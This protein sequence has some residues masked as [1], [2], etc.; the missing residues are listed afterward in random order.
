MFPVA[1]NRTLRALRLLGLQGKEGGW[2]NVQRGALEGKSGTL[3]AS[4][5]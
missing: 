2:K 1:L 4:F 5:T 3:T